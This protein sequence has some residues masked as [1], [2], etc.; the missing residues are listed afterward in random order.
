MTD[1]YAGHRG[2]MRTNLFKDCMTADRL[3][4]SFHN[5]TIKEK[6]LWNTRIGQVLMA[7]NGRTA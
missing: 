5:L 2:G 7:E 6:K 4:S 3:G 1:G